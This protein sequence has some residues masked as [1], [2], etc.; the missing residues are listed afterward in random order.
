MIIYFF[1][2]SLLQIIDLKSVTKNM[3]LLFQMGKNQSD[4]KLDLYADACKAIYANTDVFYC[5]LD[6]YTIY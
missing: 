2:L 6:S 1:I 4:L 5:A 3:R